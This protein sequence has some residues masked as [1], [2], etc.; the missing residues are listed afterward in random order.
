[1][2]LADHPEWFTW[3]ENDQPVSA[4]PGW[5][6]VVDFDFDSP[7]AAAYLKQVLQYW[8]EGFAID[9]YRCTHASLV[10]ERFWQETLADL[11]GDDGEGFFLVAESPRRSLFAAGFDAIYNPSVKG[12][13]DFA[14]M[15]DMAQP[16]LQDD[17]W[18]AFASSQR[19]Y[20]Q[21]WLV[22]H[23]ME[24]HFSQRAC[25]LYRW[26]YIRGFAAVLLTGPGIPQIY[27]GQEIGSRQ[28]PKL[29]RANPIRWDE[30]DARIEAVYRDLL[31]VRS[32]SPALRAGD[33]E[34][35]PAA[36]FELLVYTRRLGDDLI[37][38]AVN[39]SDYRPTFSLPPELASRSWR[40]WR[41][42]EFA[43]AEFDPGKSGVTERTTLEGP[44]P[45]EPCQ[46]RIWRSAAE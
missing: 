3:A 42:R 40:E 1:V 13:L 14:A 21:R 16:G 25:H 38:V 34:R 29:N 4:I 9:G 12:T 17:I 5:Q 8:R 36:S 30:R 15:D 26:P 2:Q 41:D 11:K 43:Q 44:I 27:C 7:A 46:Y 24:D 37:L 10:P 31:A 39:L 23:F 20:P 18:D 45:L 35:V 32:E 28:D 19:D 22:V 33:F 6:D